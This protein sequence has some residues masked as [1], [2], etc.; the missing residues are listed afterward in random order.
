MSHSDIPD[1]DL[2]PSLE[3][4]IYRSAQPSDVVARI[5]PGPRDYLGS[6]PMQPEPRSSPRPQVGINTL[7]YVCVFLNY[8][9]R[10]IG[11]C[12][13]CEYTHMPPFE[14]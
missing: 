1:Y 10:E 4:T 8:A 6:L 2:F 13:P 12:E 11:F 3:L 7:K 9:H 14:F 5:V